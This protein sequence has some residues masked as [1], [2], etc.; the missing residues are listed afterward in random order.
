MQIVSGFMPRRASSN[1]FLLLNIR[2]M[3]LIGLMDMGGLESAACNELTAPRPITI[4]YPFMPVVAIPSMN[5]F[6]AMKKRISTGK[7]TSTLA[8]IN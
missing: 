6:W 5:V 8:A 7:M 3:D 2:S 1:Y 4:D